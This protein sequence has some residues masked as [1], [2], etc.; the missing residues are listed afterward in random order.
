MLAVVNDPRPYDC[1]LTPCLP[2]YASQVRARLLL[3][4]SLHRFSVMPN[5][6]VLEKDITHTYLALAYK[7]R[8][9]LSQASRAIGCSK[10]EIIFLEVCRYLMST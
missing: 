5:S 4:M 6:E 10:S 7:F 3:G 8:S 1:N 9:Y 2:S